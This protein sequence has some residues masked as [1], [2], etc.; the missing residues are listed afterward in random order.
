VRSL[1][2]PGEVSVAGTAG[3]QIHARDRLTKRTVIM[4]FD[5]LNVTFSDEDAARI[6][7]VL[8]RGALTLIP[9]ARGG[10]LSRVAE[11]VQIRRSGGFCGL[12]VWLFLWM[13]FASGSTTGMKRFW[14]VAGPRSAR[15]AALVGRTKLAS[16][17]SVSR[18][19]S[20]V[21]L[22]LLRSAGD[23]LLLATADCDALL[24]HPAV[25]TYDTLGGG[26]HCFDFDPT[27]T[28]LRHRALPA[29]DDLPEPRRVSYPSQSGAIESG[30]R[31]SER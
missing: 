19:L 29:G 9:L 18:A 12:D 3:Q 20:A 25:Q 4:A 21:E 17:P 2:T 5:G 6:P 24:Q 22:D 13:Y 30:C 8:L 11:L 1:S 26:W 28:A 27:V 31:R 7:D 16:P 15:L 14:R 10:A 23:A